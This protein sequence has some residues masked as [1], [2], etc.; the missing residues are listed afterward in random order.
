M[1]SRNRGSLFALG[2]LLAATA[3][4]SWGCCSVKCCES[5]ARIA[6]ASPTGEPPASLVVISKKRKQEILWRLPATST[7]SNV[8]ITLAGK[9]APFVACATAEGVCH[10]PCE[11]T[12]CASGPI[13]PA[14]DVPSGGIYYEYAF[15]SGSS[16]SLDPGIRIDP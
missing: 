5:F 13:A 4:G 15:Q 8:A 14:L 9:P 7:T 10:I 3:L 6:V 12:L 16:A 1:V 2:S 11:H